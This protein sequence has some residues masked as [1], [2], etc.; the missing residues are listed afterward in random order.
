MTGGDIYFYD[1]NFNLLRILPSTRYK[2]IIAQQDFCGTGSLDIIFFD[3]ETGD[4]LED[5]IDNGILVIWRKFQGILT[6][7]LRDDDEYRAVGE[8]LNG[9][10]RRI[11]SE[12]Y[13]VSGTSTISSMI[14]NGL[15]YK[16]AGR[17]TWFTTTND[18]GD[19]TSYSFVSDNRMQ[20]DE[21]VKSVLDLIK[22]GYNVVADF[23]QQKYNMHYFKHTENDLV[24]SKNNLN[25]SSLSITCNNKNVVSGGWWLNKDSDFWNHLPDTYFDNTSTE[26]KFN[27]DVTY[28]DTVLSATTLTEAKKEFAKLRQKYEITLTTK[29]LDY[30][31]DYKIGDIVRLQDRGKTFKMV[32]NSVKMWEE[33]GY[34]EEPTV[35]KYEEE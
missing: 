13:T 26:Y 34:G 33:N 8:H 12:P 32:I 15:I 25:V 4:I 17:P 19:T 21:Y 23:K 35:T 20:G 14:D 5:N 10:V 18:T 3:S 2:S 31:T 27:A 28:R 24:L 9:I 11:V 7:F 6:S 29:N 22:G 30:G 16:K 1:L